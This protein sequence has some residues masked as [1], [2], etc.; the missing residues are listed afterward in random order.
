[1][2]TGELLEAL[3]HDLAGAL[4]RLAEERGIDEEVLVID[5]VRRYVTAPPH[6]DTRPDVL[7]HLEASIQENRNL[8]RLL[9]Q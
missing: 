8:Y 2:T 6:R 9:S 3:P 7:A 1:M 4:R 5:A